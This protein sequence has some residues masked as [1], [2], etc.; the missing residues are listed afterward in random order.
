MID[1]HAHIDTEAFDEDRNEV[2]Q[3]AFDSGLEAI[4]IPGIEPK[5]FERVLSIAQKHEKI[6]CGLGVHPHN[7]SDYNNEIAANIKSLAKDQNVKAIGEIGLDYYYDFTPKEVQIDAFKKQISIAKELNLPI[8]VHNRESDE[9]LL[10]VLEEMQDGTLKGVLHC[11]SSDLATLKRALDL[12]FHVSFTGNI[13]FKKS[14]LAEVVKEAPLDRIMIET[15]SPYMTPVPYRG[16]RNEPEKVS[17]VAEKIAEIK[18]ISTEEVITMTTNNAKSLFKLFLIAFFFCFGSFIMNAQETEESTTE[19]SEYVEEEYYDD[20]EYYEDEEVE[21]ADD[22]YIDE[23]TGEIMVNP[24]KRFIGF[25][26]VIGTNTIVQSQNINITPDSTVEKSIS[27]DGVV[28]YGGR[29]VWGATDYLLLEG[30]YTYS[31]N[32]KVQENNP[33]VDP[34]TYSVY[35]LT[36]HWI[37]NPK[38]R[39]N[40]FGSVGL[41]Y[42][43]SRVAVLKEDIRVMESNS[44]IGMNFGIGL[45]ANFNLGSGGL[46]ALTAEWRMDFKLNSEQQAITEYGETYPAEVSEFFSIPRFGIIWYPPF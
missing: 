13:T 18:S 29:V 15:D 35:N 30:A 41:T 31:K 7:A 45:A 24:F 37:P 33:G 3:R 42:F 28:A 44:Q 23:E 2:I 21:L 4:I 25:G 14:T 10:N 9:D 40:F 43:S 1:T 6:F 5:D 8:I 39:I 36:S 22:E 11:F 19:E 32:T 34:F 27:Y 20:D 17:F 46:L 26:P 12:G 16:K 38:N